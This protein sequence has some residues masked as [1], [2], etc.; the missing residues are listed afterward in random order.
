MN[1]EMNIYKLLD[2]LDEEITSGKKVALTGKILVDGDTTGSLDGS[3]DFVTAS[4]KWISEKYIDDAEQWGVFDA[5]RWN[6]YYAW[7]YEQGLISKEIPEN[8]TEGM[9]ALVNEW[10]NNPKKKKNPKMSMICWSVSRV[11]LPKSTKTLIR[12][13]DRTVLLWL[14]ILSN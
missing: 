4:Q 7:V 8:F 13:Y 14:T 10:K 11:W 6:R 9:K 1:E 3:L 12:I 2:R 5:D